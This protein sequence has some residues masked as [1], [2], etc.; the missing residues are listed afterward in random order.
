MS[1][2]YDNHN[3]WGECNG[4]GGVYDSTYGSVT[5]TA[6]TCW[7]CDA[8]NPSS[9]AGIQRRVVDKQ[10]AEAAELIDLRKRVVQL[11]DR[12]EFWKSIAHSQDMI[13]VIEAY[14]SAIQEC[15]AVLGGEYGDHYGYLFS[16]IESARDAA[17][18]VGIEIK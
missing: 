14:E 5:P 2:H 13:K 16:E 1:D 4:Y 11:E 9:I 18:M 3:G 17:R 10:R 6:G 7:K 15:E 12:I 8:S